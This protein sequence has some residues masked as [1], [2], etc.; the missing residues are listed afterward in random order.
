MYDLYYIG[1]DVQVSR[2]CALCV[3]DASGDCIRTEWVGTESQDRAV[4][5]LSEIVDGYAGKRPGST[6]VGIDAPRMPLP[7]LRR[8]YWDSSRS[9]WRVMRPS[10]KGF[11]RH[12]EVAIKAMGIANPQ[13]TRT[14]SES[15]AWMRLGYALFEGMPSS[16]EVYEV[17]PSASYRLAA[18]GEEIRVSIEFSEFARGPKDMLDACMAAATVRE[19]AEGRGSEIGGGDGLGSIIL[20]RPLPIGRMSEVLVWPEPDT[21]KK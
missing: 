8:H 16:V 15:P 4:L 19:F 14:L 11:G 7:A 13:W 9:A 17:F 3:I 18:A 20:P 12:C 21:M 5:E 10:D 1:I 6:S 2:G